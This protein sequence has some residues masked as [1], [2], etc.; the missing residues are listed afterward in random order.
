MT[1]D[2]STQ[3]D[4]SLL[5]GT[6]TQVSSDTQPHRRVVGKTARQRSNWP[7]SWPVGYVALWLLV[8]ASVTVNIIVLRALLMTQ[9]NAQQAIGD[10]IGMVEGL[11]ETEYV[12]TINVEDEIFVHTELPVYETIPV[13]IEETIPID[14][15][16]TVPVNAGLL[17]TITLRIPIQTT[18]PV[19]VEDE[20]LINQTFEVNTA[21]PIVMDVPINLTVAET[22][23]NAVLEDL[24]AQLRYFEQ[25]LNQPLIPF[26]GSNE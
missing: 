26:L 25:Q 15:I 3:Q 22:P 17:G 2:K 5:K 23:F 21:V 19:T 13:V 10:A 7:F 24:S 12:Y 20:V 8:L 1:D 18:V 11:Q 4:Q 6:T 14:T 9:R 16:V